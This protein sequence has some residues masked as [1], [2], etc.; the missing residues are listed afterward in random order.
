MKTNSNRSSG[1]QPPF[2]FRMLHGIVLVTGVAGCLTLRW[3]LEVSESEIR[4]A[5]REWR[6][7][8]SILLPLSRVPKLAGHDRS[9]DGSLLDR[10]GLAGQVLPLS[11]LTWHRSP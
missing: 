1:T 4:H 10:N 7:T 3:T 9:G 2:R 5:I 11:L 8:G 6:T